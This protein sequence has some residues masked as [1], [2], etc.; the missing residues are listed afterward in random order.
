MESEDANLESIPVETQIVILNKVLQLVLFRSLADWLIN[1]K[2]Q[3]IALIKAGWTNHQKIFR[4]IHAQY[5]R[6]KHNHK[7]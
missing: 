1:Y 6:D 3:I 2:A 5:L 4:Y 7:Y